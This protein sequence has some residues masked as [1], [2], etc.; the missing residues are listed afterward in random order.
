MSGEPGTNM[1][2]AGD[3]SKPV[4]VF[5]EKISAAL[6]GYFEPGQIRRIA[7]AQADAKKITA[8]A[9]I[10]VT[11]LQRRALRR[12][13]AEETKMQDNMETITAKALPQI[14]D[15]AKTENVED[16][17]ITNFFDKCRIISDESMQ[18]IW[19]KILA[20]EA[21][22]PGSYS[23]RTVN[24][25]ADLDKK[26]ANLITAFFGYCWIID[27]IAPVI[28]DVHDAIYNSHG[29]DFDSLRH[30]E[31][32]GFVSFDPLAGYSKMR[33]PRQILAHYYETPI[34][35][36]FNSDDMM[37]NKL[38]VGKAMLTTIGFELSRVCVSQPVPGFMDYVLT[39]WIRQ[40]LV[41]SSP[42]PR[43]GPH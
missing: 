6:G 40:G 13:V 8:V 7:H 43:M 42:F 16:D 22:T 36:D 28:F 19:S 3:W 38:D 1:T 26:D 21:N 12:F 20:G 11:E 41:L 23:K 37:S 5:I 10:E 4:T 35:I 14:S 34:I 33:F 31:S 32:I 24:F 15:Q 29:I 39:T 30:L 25:L 9:D 18:S 17:W 2:L 27:G